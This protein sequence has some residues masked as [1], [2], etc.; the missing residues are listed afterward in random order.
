[1]ELAWNCSGTITEPLWNHHKTIIIKPS[2]NLYETIME[3]LWNYHGFKFGNFQLANQSSRIPSEEKPLF[4]EGT[5]GPK[6]GNT[7]YIL[8]VHLY[9]LCLSLSL[10]T[11][12]I[13]MQI[14][15]VPISSIQQGTRHLTSVRPQGLF[16]LRN[17]KC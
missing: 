13:Y 15:Q 8:C 11:V 14:P 3:I 2:Q 4:G 5:K 7:V 17:Q 9:V 12:C 16:W 6:Q 1:M 10:C